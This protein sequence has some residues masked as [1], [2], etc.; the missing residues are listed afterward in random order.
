MGLGL[1]LIGL[2]FIFFIVSVESEYKAITKSNKWFYLLAALLF[3]LHIALLYF[4]GSL[5]FS[6]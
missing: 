5:L 4:G 3:L 1:I 2:A 6:L